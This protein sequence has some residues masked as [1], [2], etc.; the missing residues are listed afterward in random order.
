[1][2]GMILQRLISGLGLLLLLAGPAAAQ[3]ESAQ[4]APPAALIRLH[5]ALGLTPDQEPAWRTYA[6]AI[7]PSAAAQARHQQAAELM[8]RLPT[9]RRIAL[10]EATMAADQA[11]F[12]LQGLAVVHFYDLLSPAQQR[13]FDNQTAAP[14]SESRPLRAPPG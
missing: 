3:S 12:R 8:P 7:T 14:A 5:D 1:M 11:D 6:A 4:P 9:P 2:K 10:I 13:I